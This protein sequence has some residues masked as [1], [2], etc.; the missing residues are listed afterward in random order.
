MKTNPH[1]ALFTQHPLAQLAFAFGTGIVTSN[2]LPTRPSVLL[3]LFALLSFASLLSLLV[4]RVTA[5]A[6]AVLL[7]LF[8][9]G[10]LLAVLE[11]GNSPAEGLKRLIA[12]E[13]IGANDPVELTGILDG[14]PEFAR[15]RIYLPLK[16]VSVRIRGVDQRAS[17]KVVLLA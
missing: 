8:C 11:R 13:A 14:P 2:A 6:Y 7:A 10:A 4:N 5:T 16:V 1:H 15:D 17:G 3:P 9:A 12:K